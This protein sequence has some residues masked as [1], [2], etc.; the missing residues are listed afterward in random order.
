MKNLRNEADAEDFAQEVYL[1]FSRLRN[2]RK[3]KSERAFLFTTAINLL[4]DRSR[5]L[6]TQLDRASV[7]ID[8]VT[9]ECTSGDPCQRAVYAEQLL[10]MKAALADVKENCRSAFWMS[11]VDGKSYAEIADLMGVSVS[12][13]EKHI[14]AALKCLRQALDG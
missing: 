6:A 7:S 8:D 4:R 1:R 2:H 12:M 10:L 13:V 5:R 3:I 14:S 9:L 11:R